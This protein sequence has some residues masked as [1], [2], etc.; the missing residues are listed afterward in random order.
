MAYRVEFGPAAARQFKKLIRPVQEVITKR[1][2]E[3][4]I[5]PRPPGVKKL[6]GEENLYRVR[7]GDYRIVYEIQ[8]QALLVIVVKVGHRSD[9]YK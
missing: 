1:L 2:E 3:L 9:V 7:E 8:D 5:N 4:A 6:Q